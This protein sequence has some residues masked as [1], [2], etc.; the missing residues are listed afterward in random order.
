M[1]YIG[2]NFNISLYGKK[3]NNNEKKNVQENAST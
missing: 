2:I 1:F 3:K